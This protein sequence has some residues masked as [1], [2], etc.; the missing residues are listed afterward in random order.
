[1]SDYGGLLGF[2]TGNGTKTPPINGGASGGMSGGLL[3]DYDPEEEKMRRIGSI[4][5]ALLA[6][7]GY[8][9]QKRG[10]GE[11]L[12]KSLLDAEASEDNYRNSAL[13][14]AMMMARLKELGRPDYKTVGNT[15]G[16]F[17]PE[18]GRF[19]PIYTDQAASAPKAPSGYTWAADGKTL[20]AIPGGPA[21]Q[22]PAEVAGRVGLAKDFLKQVPGIKEKIS[23]GAATGPLDYIYGSLGYGDSGV[24]MKEIEGGKEALIRQLTGA[25]QS[26]TEAKKYADQYSASFRDTPNTLAAKLDRLQRRLV[27]SG[28]QALVGRGGGTIA[29]SAPSASPPPSGKKAKFLGFE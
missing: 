25:G 23:T 5:A 11:I 3:A 2:F 14:R 7:S 22:L 4:G 29:P 18:T 21:T 17:D 16:K 27:A 28:D 9:T 26:E 19:E 8:S 13:N 20:E 10:F 1:M 24:V 15:L 6:N 12:G